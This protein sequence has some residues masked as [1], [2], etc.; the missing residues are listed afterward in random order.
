MRR[1][2]FVII[3][4]AVAVFAGWYYWKV[5]LQISSAPV[6]TLL[7]QGTIF[8]A[9]LPD[10]NRTRDDWHHCDIYHLYREPAVQDFLR[11]AIAG[12]SKLP[13]TNAAYHTLQEIEKLYHKYSYFAL[14]NIDKN[15]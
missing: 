15:N 5:S 4:L 6:S 9:H 13:K 3:A 7:P 2:I 1:L 8:L 14:T 12:L 10:F 11:P